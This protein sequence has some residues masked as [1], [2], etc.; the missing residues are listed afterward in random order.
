MEALGSGKIS[1]HYLAAR[2]HQEIATCTVYSTG[3]DNNLRLCSARKIHS[4]VTYIHACP[5]VPYC[6]LSQNFPQY[7]HDLLHFLNGVIVDK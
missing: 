3:I 5:P 2:K 4:D 7:T 1:F 6:A